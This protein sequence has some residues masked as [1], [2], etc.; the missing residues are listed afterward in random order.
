M[1]A[2][3]DGGERKSSDIV[4]RSSGW[5]LERRLTQSREAAKH[6]STLPS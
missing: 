3:G 4:D 2:A 5:G 6:G 1:G